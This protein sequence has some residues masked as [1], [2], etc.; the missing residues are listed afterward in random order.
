M[1][2]NFW[3]GVVVGDTNYNT[4]TQSLFAGC[5]L[6]LTSNKAGRWYYELA[7][8]GKDGQYC[9]INDIHGIGFHLW[10]QCC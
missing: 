10:P 5:H 6:N 1:L 8:A 4:R 2:E 7:Q 9:Y 3:E